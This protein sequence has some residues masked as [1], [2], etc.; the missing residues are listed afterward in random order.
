MVLVVAIL[1]LVVVVV[2]LVAI[3]ADY[4]RGGSDGG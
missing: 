4:V 1:L 3:G 2:V